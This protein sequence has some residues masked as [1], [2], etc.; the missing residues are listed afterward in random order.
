MSGLWSSD[1]VHRVTRRLRS[2]CEAI[3]GS[4]FDTPEAKSGARG[5]NPT[6]WYIDAEIAQVTAC[7]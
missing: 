2:R 7:G 3:Y 5:L 6:Q 4:V 1:H